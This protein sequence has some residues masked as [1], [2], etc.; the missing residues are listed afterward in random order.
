MSEK[1]PEGGDLVLHVQ[2][3]SKK[4]QNPNARSAINFTLIYM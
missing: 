3:V 2:L 1:L 4:V